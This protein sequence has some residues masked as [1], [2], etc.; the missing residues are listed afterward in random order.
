M[1]YT[2][3]YV[4]RAIRDLFS[5]KSKTYGIIP[6]PD[7]GLYVLGRGLKH[8]I[9]KLYLKFDSQF[10]DEKTFSNSLFLWGKKDNRPGGF[11]LTDREQNCLGTSLNGGRHELCMIAIIKPKRLQPYD[12]ERSMEDASIPICM[13]AVLSEF[14]CLVAVAKDLDISRLWELEG[15]ELKQSLLGNAQKEGYDSWMIGCGNF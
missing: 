13:K 10:F 14:D 15:E 12:G 4:D 1:N 11:I 8:E 7:G 6:H 5:G 9:I 3:A 2:D